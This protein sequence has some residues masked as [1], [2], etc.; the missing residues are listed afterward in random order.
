MMKFWARQSM[1]ANPP[2]AKRS[3]TLRPACVVLFFA[4]CCCGVQQASAQAAADDQQSCR[5]F[6]QKFYDWYWNSDAGQADM[7]GLR[8][9]TLVEVLKLKPPVLGPNLLKLLKREARE[10]QTGN[11]GFDPFLNSNGPHS[12]YLVSKVEVSGDVCRATIDAGHEIAA[13]KKS[14]PNWVFVDFHY[15]YYYDDGSKRATPDADLI[16]LLTS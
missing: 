10:G 14:G 12:K 13:L 4:I 8:S 16:Q 9:H 1:R 7:P 2:S 11:L 3:R 6:V 15:S 5:A